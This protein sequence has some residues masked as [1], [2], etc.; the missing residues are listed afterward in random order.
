MTLEKLRKE[1]DKINIRILK[2]LKERQELCIYMALNKKKM[3]LSMRDEKREEEM[4]IELDEQAEKMD[5]SKDFVRQLFRN[6]IDETLR[7]EER[8]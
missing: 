7:V 5:L 6:I 3:G 2:L 1:M 4:L 8:Q